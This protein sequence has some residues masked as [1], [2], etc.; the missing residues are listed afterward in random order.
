[1]LPDKRTETVPALPSPRD[2]R[3]LAPGTLIGGRYEI[4]D[5]LGH[6]GH[7]TVYRVFD[8]EVRRD[9]ALK[10]LDPQRE[11]ESGFKRLRREVQ[12]ARDAESPRLVRIFDLGTSPQGTFLTMELVDGPSLRG[13]L[14]GDPLPIGEAVRIAI[15]LFEGLAV[16]HG[17]A[18]IHRDIKPGNIL[19]ALGREVKLADFGL[20]RRLDREETQ[21]TLSEGLVGTLDYLS[22]EQILGKEA[23]KGSDLYAAGLVLFEMLAGRLP[24]EAASEL[25]RQLGPLQRAPSVRTLRPEVPRWLAGVVSR[26]LEV[27]PADRYPSAEEALR[28]LTREK[29]PR[30]V[31]LRRIFVRV[32]VVLLFCLPQTGVL[33][34]SAPQA[35]F[36]HLVPLGEAGI[37]A[38][39]TAGK[40]LWTKPR[41]DPETAGKMAMARIEP[42]GPRLMAVVLSPK[43]DWTPGAITKLSFL[44]PQT[45]RV[46]K[47]VRLPWGAR[48]FPSDPPRF[49]V[50]SVTAVDLFHDGVDDV[51]VSY[52]HVPESPSYAVFYSPRADR[53]RIVFY[54]QGGH[55][56]QGATDVDH[57]GTPDLL[58]TGIN[59]GWNWV[60]AVAAVRLDPWPW[61]DEQWMANPTAS[62]DSA[63]EPSKERQLLWYAVI[64]RGYLEDS[65]LK[66]DEG[67]RELRVCFASGKVWTLGFG[68]FPPGTPAVRER[69]EARR[70]TYRH[71]REAERLR[72]AG[73]L[74]LAMAEAQAARD[75]AARAHDVWL[76]QY[77]ERIAAKILVNEGKVGE[78]EAL[79][80]SLMARAEDA[81]EVAYDA[82]VAFHLHGDLR[83]AVSWYERGIGRGAAMG[84]GKSKHEFLKG[85]VLALVE[86]KRYDEALK[87]VDRFGATFY[88]AWHEHL[89]LFREYVR[90]RA[91]ERPQVD[92]PRVL[93]SGTDL[94]RYWALE[95]EFAAGG[96]PQEILPR[97]DGF[98]A[99]RPE[100][101]AEAL[102]LRAALLSRL[103]RGKEA[104]DAAQSA[105]ELARVEACRN[106]IARGHLDLLAMRAHDLRDTSPRPRVVGSLGVQ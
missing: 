83:R 4:R 5:Y 51:L 19:L 58:F 40:T 44:E 18:I 98:L 56:F 59:N 93:P 97:V 71:F 49:D 104:E 102:S 52:R 70:E 87:A 60:N 34:V 12:V 65:G 79:F 96:N 84:A 43:Y 50:A 25:G 8:R 53:A 81:P 28:D 27:R 13:L 67:R 47:E 32:A 105:F 99:E 75:A 57:D 62:P 23:G 45:G 86:E 16:L 77:A 88:P 101:Q 68:G 103:G 85:E 39:D 17:L 89:W 90:W 29:S 46:V 14:T 42:G 73:I 69:N 26:L 55:R 21:V 100:T 74:D 1:M 78:A 22:P 95:F 41:V 10:L 63:D 2:E 82:A 30:Q 92:L 66:I 37:A 31:R 94:E 61:T 72:R 20:A 11:T 7:G 33:L 80:S 91:G 24:Q 64:P 9:V 76:S 36:S 106:I 15:Q 48:Y 35:T 6:G 38:I 3:R 54:S